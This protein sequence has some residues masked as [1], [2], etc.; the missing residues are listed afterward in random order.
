MGDGTEEEAE[1]ALFAALSAKAGRYVLSDK[2]KQLLVPYLFRELG[3]LTLSDV[4]SLGAKG[5]E[6]ALDEATDGTKFPAPLR[7]GG[8]GVTKD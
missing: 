4:E 1:D 6:E 7:S 3:L 8:R 5:F 2:L